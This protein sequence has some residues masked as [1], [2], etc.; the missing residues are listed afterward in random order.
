MITYYT[1]NPDGSIAASAEF[2][3]SEDCQKT[4]KEIVRGYDGKLYFADKAPKKPQDLIAAERDAAFNAAISTRL[5]AFIALKGYD[6]M[7][8]ARLTLLSDTFHTD[9]V[10]AQK[11][12]DDTWQAAIELIPA[13]TSGALS[14]DDA[15]AQLP[16]IEWPK[17]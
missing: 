3:F 4:N 6:S 2:K 14:I 13:V 5:N 8:K 10:V 11:A 17:D 16:A 9:G 12:Y 15:L 7:D 1:L